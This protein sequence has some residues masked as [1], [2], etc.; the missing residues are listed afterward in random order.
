MQPIVALGC[1]LVGEY[2]IHRLADDGHQVAAVDLQIPKSLAN[3][4][5]V[6][7]IEQDAYQY[8][9][10]LKEPAI[11]INMLP[12]RIGHVIRIPLIRGGHTNTGCDGQATFCHN[13]L[14]HRNSSWLVEH[15]ACTST[16]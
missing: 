14:G 3:R 1:G 2:V 9:E 12:G 10:S 5:E 4:K 8:V 6:L 11:I 13:D 7:S 15:A 16:T